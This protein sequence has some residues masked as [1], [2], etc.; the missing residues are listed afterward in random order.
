VL[1]AIV[2]ANPY[3]ASSSRQALNTAATLAALDKGHK[4]AVLFLDDEEKDNGMSMSDRL[5]LV[6]Q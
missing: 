6:Q 5:K 1:L 4:L 3:L 2:D